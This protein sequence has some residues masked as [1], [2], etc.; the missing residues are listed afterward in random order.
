MEQ[1]REAWN[2]PFG[3]VNQRISNPPYL[4]SGMPFGT[5]RTAELNYS[6]VEIPNGYPETFKG[7]DGMN[8]IVN[9]QKAGAYVESVFGPPDMFIT[10]EFQATLQGEHGILLMTPIDPDYF[11]AS[12]HI[13][14]YNGNDCL[15]GA[16]YFDSAINIKF[17]ILK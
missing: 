14:L 5:S 1:G 7:G 10:S 8:Y 2:W 9:A 13:T 15:S 11:N 17:W 4:R 12:G 3:R 6:G 16:C